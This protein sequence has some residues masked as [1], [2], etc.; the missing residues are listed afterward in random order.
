MNAA[1]VTELSPWTH[2]ER[3]LRLADGASLTSSRS[4]RD[5]VARLAG[6]TAADV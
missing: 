3:T 6:E 5:A 2:G 4:Y 1:H